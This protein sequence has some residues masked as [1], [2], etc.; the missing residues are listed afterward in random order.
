MVSVLQVVLV[1]VLSYAVNSQDC[2]ELQI[3][4]LGNTTSESQTGLLADTLRVL[5]GDSTNRAVQILEFNTVCLSQGALKD[6]YTRTSVVV[7]YTADGVE[8]TSQVEYQ[9]IDGVWEIP[10][11]GTPAIENSPIANLT[12]PVRTDCILCS[13]SGIITDVEHCAGRSVC[14]HVYKTPAREREVN[15]RYLRVG[16]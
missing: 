7:R 4:D 16:K 9:C 12:T 2:S 13:S 6:T 5:G 10:N 14:M 1:A 3:S 8:A 11:T 15:I